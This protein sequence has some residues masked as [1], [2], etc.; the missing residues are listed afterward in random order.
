MTRKPGVTPL[1]YEV[2]NRLFEAARPLSIDEV[3]NDHP[4]I[5]P[6]LIRRG[7]A[8]SAKPSGYMITDA[9][10]AAI[11]FEIVESETAPISTSDRGSGE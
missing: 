7:W 3:M 1:R 11:G 6:T 9:G 5:M 8:T 2:L 4:N 10:M